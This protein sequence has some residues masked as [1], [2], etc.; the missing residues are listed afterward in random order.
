M[1]NTEATI[2]AI[3]EAG[4][5][6][7]RIALIRQ[8]PETYG[9]AH[10]RD[11]YSA[12]AERIYVPYLT[13]DFA[14]VHHRAEYSLEVVTTAVR[15][16]R[17]TTQDFTA[18]AVDQLEHALATYPDAMLAFR[19]IV[20]FTPQEIAA[21]TVP[22]AAELGLDSVNNNQV[23]R[24]EA[25][26][27]Q[28]AG[29]VRLLA[30]T[31]SRAVTRD[32]FPSPPTDEVRSKQDR[33]DLDDGWETVRHLAVQG[34]P[35]EM[36]LHQRHYGGAFRQLLDATSSLRGNLL[37]D[38]VSD[39]FDSA[40]IP[41]VRTGNANQAEIA[42]RFH[43]T[44]Q[45]APDFVVYDDDNSARAFLECKLVNDGGTAR[46]KAAR[47]I[48]L[49][50]AAAMLGGLPV[51]AVLGGLGWRRT[52]DALGPVVEACDGRVFTLANLQEMLTVDPFPALPRSQH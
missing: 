14:Y 20:G 30:E 51:F 47:F 36:F 27:H 25:G 7:Q 1:T 41:S 6:T 52:S 11:V 33:P 39:L 15:H 8:I 21:A 38:A 28:P 45:P 32:L 43:L 17:E 13:P 22:V 29:V 34:V 26:N 31:V 10:L 19:L 42:T 35:Y 18:V 3:E 49:R 48:A 2:D 4:S 16:A 46:D 44:V 24:L 37:E 9:R 12:V 23:R 50:Q 5:W 40:A